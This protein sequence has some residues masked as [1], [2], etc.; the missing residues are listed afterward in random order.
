MLAEFAPTRCCLL[1]EV[2][3]QLWMIG[4]VLVVLAADNTK[5]SAISFQ[6]NLLGPGAT[7]FFQKL[8]PLFI[9]PLDS[10]P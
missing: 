9:V 7:I 4:I 2:D 5:I 8:R 3:R 1:V 6:T 10:G